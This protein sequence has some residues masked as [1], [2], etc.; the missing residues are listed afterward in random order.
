MKMLL[1]LDFQCHFLTTMLALISFPLVIHFYPCPC[2]Q[3]FFWRWKIRSLWWVLWVTSMT[4]PASCSLGDV[5]F[6]PS[7]LFFSDRVRSQYVYYWA[8]YEFT[9][10]IIRELQNSHN[11]H[12]LDV[13][14]KS[15]NIYIFAS[16]FS[17]IRT[18]DYFLLYVGSFTQLLHQQ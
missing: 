17:K 3:M 8:L 14:R 11:I 10:S 18:A 5:L 12:A 15:T 16:M 6:F 13:R 7:S 9:Y 2:P 4:Y 1:A